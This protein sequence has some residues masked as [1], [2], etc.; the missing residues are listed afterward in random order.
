[1]G[2]KKLKSIR[3][4][5]VDDYY[6]F[7]LEEAEPA[8]NMGRQRREH[9]TVSTVHDIHK[10]VRCAFNLAVKWDYI[11]TNPFIK[12][13]LPEHRE[14]E[15][16]VLEP[17]QV[18]KILD[19]TCR[20]EYYDYYLM[21]CAIHLAIAC[22]MRGGEIVPYNGIVLIWLNSVSALIALSTVLVRKTQSSL[23]MQILFTFP[24]LYPGTKTSIM[25]KQPKTEGSIR[26]IDVPASTIQALAG[27][28]ELQENL[29]KEL[30]P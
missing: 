2:D 9:V 24:N 16:K 13:T 5:T 8:A 3:T 27:L 7:L 25:L 14:Q 15:R 22:T 4:K 19:F 23:K 26:E 18:L 28:R 1:M 29:K 17:E 21:H 12:A 6:D 10:V 11:S 20:K 30:G